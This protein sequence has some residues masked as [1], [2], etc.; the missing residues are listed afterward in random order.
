MI[1]FT[2]DTHFQHVNILK[3]EPDRKFRDL[4]EHDMK[5]IEN[6]NNTVYPADTVYHIGDFCMGDRNKL[7]SIKHQLN[8]EI[9][10][11]AG[12]HDRMHKTGQIYPQIHEAFGQDM[13]HD[14]LTIEHGGFKIYMRHEP[15]MAFSPIND[16]HIHL[17]GHVHSAWT[18]L[19]SIINVGADVCG[20]RPMT[21]SELLSRKNTTGKSH[22]NE[23]NTLKENN[24]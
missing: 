14:E 3:Y 19:G 6:W 22:R 7:A 20:L 5:L 17:A 2:S 21:L 24:G 18:R 16:Q 13:V 12:N 1:F 11:I 8:G 15:D 4:A 23:Y 9:I 10:L